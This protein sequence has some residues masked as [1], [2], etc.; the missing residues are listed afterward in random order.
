MNQVKKSEKSFPIDIEGTN[1][2]KLNPI[3]LI[4]KKGYYYEKTKTKTS[5]LIKLPKT[6]FFIIKEVE[7]IILKKKG[8]RLW[9]F[10]IVR[11]TK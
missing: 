11:L 3:S 9:N 5:S 4:N 7:Y 10:S 1:N 6:I 8:K 2:Q